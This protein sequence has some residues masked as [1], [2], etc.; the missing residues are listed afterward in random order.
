MSSTGNL[1]E[2]LLLPL[3]HNL[4]VVNT[5]RQVHGSV[6]AD[7]LLGEESLVGLF[8]AITDSF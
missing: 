4:A 6:Q 2:N 1:E 5:P 8:A 7:Q 3:E